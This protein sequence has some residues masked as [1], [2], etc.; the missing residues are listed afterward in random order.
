[1]QLVTA[2]RANESMELESQFVVGGHGERRDCALDQ[3]DL[4]FANEL[5]DGGTFSAALLHA[6]HLLAFAV[7][8]AAFVCTTTT[9]DPSVYGRAPRVRRNIVARRALTLTGSDISTGNRTRLS[10][11]LGA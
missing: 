7:P 10:A 5:F 4:A 1:M 8:M 11:M 2:E 9:C 3:Y 6:S